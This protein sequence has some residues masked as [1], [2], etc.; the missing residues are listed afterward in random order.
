M[1]RLIPVLALCFAP[2]ALRA[3]EAASDTAAYR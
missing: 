1:R 3:Q 2:A